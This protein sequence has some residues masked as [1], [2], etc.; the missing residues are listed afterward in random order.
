MLRTLLSI[1]LLS[2]SALALADSSLTE[3]E[4][5]R[6]IDGAL[7]RIR[8]TYLETGDIERIEAG[9]R[10]KAAKGEYRA[11]ATPEAFATQLQEDLRKVSGDPHFFMSYIAGEIPPLPTSMKPRPEPDAQRQARFQSDAVL[12]NNG[13]KRVERLDDNVGVI[14]LT[15]VFPA[16]QMPENAAAAMTFLKNTSAL[17]L[18][19]REVR[20]GDPGGVVHLRSYFVDGRI[21]AYDFV[22]RKSE[23]TM[24]YF[25][26]AT[27][28][29]PRYAPNK[30]VF[31]LTSSRTFSGG[32]A[33]TD[34]M[35]TWRHAKV[36]GERTKGGANSALP[37]KATDH[38]VVVVPFMKTVNLLTGKN[39]NG[40]GIEPDVAVPAEK[41]L[42]TARQLAL[43]ATQTQRER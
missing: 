24:E 1:L 26:D 28:P 6:V 18:D 7:A 36:I 20:G 15:S 37:V 33:M 16:E 2:G 42:D 34:A 10:S 43:G 21:H 31:V 30:P 9:I 35:R 3:A 19:L 32:E 14:V 38:F 11:A 22:G 41:A 12:R 40:T 23:D 8:E 17:V 5:A 27:T 25:T 4:Q 29:G 13:F 39:W